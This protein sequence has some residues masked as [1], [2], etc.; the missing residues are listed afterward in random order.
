MKWG[1]LG[2]V[3]LTLVACGGTPTPQAS[4]QRTVQTVS[5]KVSGWTGQGRVTVP[6]LPGVSSSV[7][8]DG[9]FVLTLP[10]DAEV[11]GQTVRATDVA[12][13]LSCSGSVQSSDSEAR[14]FALLFLDTQDSAGTRQTSAVTGSV[15]GPLSRRVDVRVW[16]YSDSVTQLR[17][18]VDC[19]KI[20]SVPQIS[21]L[22]VTVA[23][24]ARPGWNV[25][26]LNIEASANV[27]TQVSASGSMV[28]STAVN[29]QN[30]F[31]TIEE[32]Q[33]QIAF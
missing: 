13:R 11:A 16:V 26:E 7:D 8:A 24:N 18:T 22:P 25:V 15:S 3:A 9:S 32:L 5:G 14:V 27:L 30:T 31:R 2:G 19:A 23:V 4:D 29:A 1:L 20:L 28:N 10:G 21:K 12:E 17:G 6:G 33:A